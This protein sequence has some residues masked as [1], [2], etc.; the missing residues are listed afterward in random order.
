M[1]FEAVTPFAA[2]QPNT[3]FLARTARA[4]VLLVRL[5][6]D[7]VVAFSPL[8][9]HQLGNL[10]DGDCRA[11]TLDCPLHGYRFD[12]LTGASI[13]PRGEYRLR[14][15]DVKIEDGQVW[16]HAPQPKWMEE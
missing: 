10:A 14:F 11:D 1:N 9:P 5:S 13:Y 2:L 16:V 4:R 7:R 15:F 12:L 6:D 3:P 8:C